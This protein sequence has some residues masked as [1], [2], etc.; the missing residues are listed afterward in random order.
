M[1]SFPGL[2]L[3]QGSK[4]W[5]KELVRARRRFSGCSGKVCS[6][7]D[8]EF[9]W[10][11]QKRRLAQLNR[12]P[13]LP[14]ALATSGTAPCPDLPPIPFRHLQMVG[15]A[16]ATVRSPWRL[17][18]TDSWQPLPP[19]H[20]GQASSQPPASS[21]Q[22]AAGLQ[23]LPTGC[24]GGLLLATHFSLAASIQKQGSKLRQMG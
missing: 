6:E 22:G 15:R 21:P 13:G 12:W 9:G 19:S 1:V 24:P 8:P 17:L 16:A 4:S 3:S 20:S 23:G 5:R 2:R 11:P 7:A 18:Q 10:E 14:Q